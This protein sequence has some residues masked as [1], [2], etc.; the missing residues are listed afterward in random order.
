[1][2]GLDHRPLRGAQCTMD[3]MAQYLNPMEEPYL[4]DYPNK[5]LMAFDRMGMDLPMDRTALEPK[6]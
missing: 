3:F 4:L 1:M 5:P 6:E 2:R